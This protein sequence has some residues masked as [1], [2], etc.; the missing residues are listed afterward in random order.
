MQTVYLDNNATTQPAPQVVAAMTDV[1]NEWWGN[2]SSGHRLGQAARSKVE[3]ARA[4][5]ARLIGVRDRQVVF[6]SGGTEANNL[7]LSGVLKASLEKAGASPRPLVI[8]TDVEHPSIGEPIEHLGQRGGRVVT[9]PVD[10]NGLVDP[11]DL[12]AAL[13]SGA[14]NGR[15]ALVSIQW[16]N[17]ETGVIQPIGDLVAACRRH[18]E[19][20]G[21]C[22]VVFHTDATQAVGKVVV[23]AVASG[24]DLL[25]LSGHKF[26]GPKGVG[27]L[28]VKPG[29][30]LRRQTLGGHQEHDRRGGTENVPSIVGLGVAA[31]LAIRFLGDARAVER[32]TAL[33]NRLERGI[34]TALPG[35][36]VHASGAKRLW[37]T[38][39]LGFTG[40]EAEAVLL[41]LSE[42]GVCASAG[43][44]CSSGSL[45]PSPVLLAM[46]IPEAVAHGSTRFSLSR[47]TGD[48][49][50]D[51]ALDVVPEVVR[52]L[53]RTLPLGPAS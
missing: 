44:A 17:N 11:K 51:R 28:Y 46:G 36:V 24:V 18:T 41:A 37:N 3:L 49:Q 6:T 9:L 25:S 38:S 39:N 8:S 50:I 45:D 2:P 30:R 16:A 31:D 32:Q 15:L 52:H 7:A 20:C 43:S 48:E 1:L 47:D 27:S 19:A 53:E 12:V 35:T 4:S 42:K 23:D 14:C 21:E 26:H 29:T 5:V 33:R 13:E 10:G 34:S 40:I 22:R